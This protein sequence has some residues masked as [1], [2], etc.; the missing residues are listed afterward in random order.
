MAVVYENLSA[1]KVDQA[2]R[3]MEDALASSGKALKIRRRALGGDDDGKVNGR[4]W[5]CT[6]ALK[7]IGAK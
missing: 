6:I 7:G 4:V 2:Q 1:I 5:N 3:L